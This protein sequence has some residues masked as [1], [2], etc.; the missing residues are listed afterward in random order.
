M[1][2][3]GSLGTLINFKVSDESILTFENFQR[4]ISSRWA[5][6]KVIQKKPKG[7][8]V[9]ADLQTISFNIFLDAELGV[10]PSE[11]L[12][13]IREAVEAGRHYTFVVGARQVGELDWIITDMSETWDIVLDHGELLRATCKLSLK[14]YDPT[15]NVNENDDGSFD[16]DSIND[17]FGIGE[18]ARY[19]GGAVYK[20][21][22]D[23]SSV[24]GYYASGAVMIKDIMIGRA[25]PYKIK[26]EKKKQTKAN[27]WVDASALSKI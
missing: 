17:V 7:E 26:Y 20:S 15:I 21:S 3:I 24:K 19:N 6:H 16:A 9:G 4:K 1:A 27:G 10:K 11:T 25:H 22:K 2:D 23:T 12:E 14:E 13:T 18:E 5:E 8:Y